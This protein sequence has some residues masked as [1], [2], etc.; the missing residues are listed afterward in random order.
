MW[1]DTVH[2]FIY[3]SFDENLSWFYFLAIVDGEAVDEDELVSLY[4]IQN[5]LGIPRRGT[6]EL[7]GDSSTIFLKHHTEF[8]SGYR[9]SL[10]ST[11]NKGSSFHTIS[12]S[13]VFFFVFATCAGARRKLKVVLICKE[14]CYSGFWGR[15]IIDTI[16]RQW[17]MWD[18]I[19]TDIGTFTHWWNSGVNAMVI[20]IPYMIGSKAYWTGQYSCLYIKMDL[21]I[22]SWLRQTSRE[23]PILFYFF[24]K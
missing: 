4:R 18:S 14:R 9:V 11:M 2:F 24:A 15:K 12:P 5:P 20:N 19:T 8:H 21:R 3:S 23:N 10:L 6:A 1:L 17:T 7:Y 16:T 22:H 13:C